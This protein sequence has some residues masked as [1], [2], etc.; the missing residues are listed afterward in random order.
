MYACVADDTKTTCLASWA[1][2]AVPNGESFTDERRR[3][4]IGKHCDLTDKPFMLLCK[5]VT[6][7]RLPTGA[8]TMFK[9][10]RDGHC[11]VSLLLPLYHLLV[12]REYGNEPHH[13]VSSGWRV[14]QFPGTDFDLRPVTGSPSGTPSHL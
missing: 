4:G 11:P 2:W 12:R 6:S 10:K 13:S 1:S 5:N 14:M 9:A 8:V 7:A 3:F